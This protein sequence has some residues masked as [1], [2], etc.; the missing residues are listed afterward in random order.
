MSYPRCL[1]RPQ[2]LNIILDN[3]CASVAKIGITLDNFGALWAHF[4]AVLAQFRLSKVPQTFER[5][6]IFKPKTCIPCTSVH[7][8]V[9]NKRTGE[10]P[11]NPRFHFQKYYFLRGYPKD[12][13]IK[14]AIIIV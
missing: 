8:V 12:R 2:R 3:R 10:N 6:S 13:P 9:K 5:M 14:T 7:S 4:G 1:Q 11:R